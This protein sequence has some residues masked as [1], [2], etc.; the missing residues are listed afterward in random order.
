MCRCTGNGQRK[1]S[2]LDRVAA[3][4]H[5]DSL[6]GRVSERVLSVRLAFVLEPDC[7]CSQVAALVLVTVF[8]IL[9][10]ARV[11][12]LNVLCKLFTFFPSRVCCGC[13]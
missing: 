8:S 12:R 9:D 7:H 5:W 6:I 11:I 2:R 1:R 10:K 13:I 4:R 3:E